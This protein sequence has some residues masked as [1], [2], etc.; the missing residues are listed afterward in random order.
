MHGPMN[1]K[2]VSFYFSQTVSTEGHRAWKGYFE[3]FQ[4]L[5]C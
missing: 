4:N 5:H 3:T 1:V 2:K